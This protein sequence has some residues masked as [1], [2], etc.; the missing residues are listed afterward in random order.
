MDLVANGN[1]TKHF[2]IANLTRDLT[3]EDAILDLVDNSIDAFVRKHDLDVSAKLLRL[4]PV[5]SQNNTPAKAPIRVSVTT[6]QVQVSDESGGIPLQHA[7]TK[8]FRLGRIDASEETVLGVYGVGLKRAMFKIGNHVVIESRTLEDGFRLEVDLKQW[9]DETTPWDFPLQPIS[10]ATS[11]DK[12]GTTI[13]ISELTPEVALRIKDPTLLT[14]LETGIGM[15]YTL[16]LTRFLTISLNDHFVEARP[17]PIGASDE[18]KPAFRE[19]TVD[20][21]SVELIAG[22]AARE[23]GEW[24][25]DRAGWYVLCNGRVVVNADKTELTGW[26]VGAPQFVSKY[27]GFVGIAFFFSP[28]PAHL[29]WT[30]TKRGLNQ[31]ASVFQMARGEMVVQAKPVIAFLNK[32]YSSEPAPQLIERRMA[33]TVQAIDVRT[34]TNRP[35]GV[36]MAKATS[37][38]KRKTEVFIRYQ[39]SLTEIDKVRK[40]I[41]QPK[42]GTGAVG[43]YTFEYFLRME[44]SE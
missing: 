32:M 4:E 18:V 37:V 27:R 5:V 10:K 13:T 11:A 1:P 16:F 28:N 39:A 41:N 6:K 25:V 20:D 7:I 44:C 22:L 17:L 2:F 21:V 42:L 35:T 8:V 14:R 38:S 34:V 31:E 40:R 15:T 26:G 23:N 24:N 12:A 33:D 19:M 43:R 36:F 9:A 3:L 29:P 30:T